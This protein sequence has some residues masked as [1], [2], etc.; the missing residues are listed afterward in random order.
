MANT[1]IEATYEHNR[2]AF[3]RDCAY[4]ITQ[5]QQYAD[6][7]GGE[8]ALSP[9]DRRIYQGR[10][11]RILRLVAYH[12]GAQAYIADLQGWIGEL[13]Q[14]NRR[15]SVQ[16]SEAENGWKHFFPRLT[17]KEGRADETKREYDRQ[18]S[19]MKAQMKWAELY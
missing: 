5:I 4:M 18:M 15:L 1:F 17:G 16:V 2:E 9:E 11:D 7:K 3:L 6:N 12:D 19:L 14:T 13:I 8:T 10:K